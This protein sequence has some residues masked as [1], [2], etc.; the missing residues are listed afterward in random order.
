MG[1]HMTLN[2]M[3]LV[4]MELVVDIL[5]RVPAKSVCRIRCVSKML[6]SIID[7]PSFVTLHFTFLLDPDSH[8]PPDPPQFILHYNLSSGLRFT[9]HSLHYDLSNAHGAQLNPRLILQSSNL[10]Y[11]SLQFV[12][13]NMF[14]IKWGDPALIFLIDPLR[15]EVLKLPPSPVCGSYSHSTYVSTGMGFDSITNTY[16]IL[17]VTNILI[18]NPSGTESCCVSQVLVLGTSEWRQVTSAPPP[19]IS[20]SCLENVRTWRYALAVELL[21]KRRN[22]R[23]STY[24]VFRLQERRVLL[25]SQSLQITGY[26]LS[27]TLDQF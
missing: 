4:P 15:G 14:C 12:F 1:S 25:D 11:Y 8:L 21:H 20:F 19:G 5:R 24:T 2:L 13:C 27:V 23:T 17:H 3:E 7:S 26:V 22:S 9:F 18:Y 10:I 6:L 16:K